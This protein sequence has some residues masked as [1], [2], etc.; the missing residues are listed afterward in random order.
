MSADS[1]SA[2]DRDAWRAALSGM[3]LLVVGMGVGRFA[4]TP[5]LP[6]LREA[7]DWP[8][9]Q[10]GDVASANY[11][12]YVIGALAAAGIA[13]R[14]RQYRWLAVAALASALTTAAG[15]VLDS[16]FGW[17]LLRAA[18]GV[19]SAFVLVLG[20]AIVSR[21]LLAAGRPALAAVYFGG[22]G[23]GIVFSV[24][25]IE[26]GE[27]A[28]LSVFGQWASLGGI[29]VLFAIAALV[30]LGA[31]QAGD[32]RAQDGPAPAP[33]DDSAPTLEAP[34]A[35]TR[36]ALV[37]LIIAYGLFG[38]G[39]VVTATFIVQMA[40]DLPGARLAEPLSWLAVGLCAIPSTA[41]WQWLAGRTGTWR[42]LRIAFLTEAVGV[43]LAGYGGGVLALAGGGAL[44]GGT[45]VGITALGLAAA[46]RI[47]PLRADQV[48][49]WMTAAFGIGQW[50]GPAAAGRLAEASG[51]FALPSLLAA[52]LLGLGFLLLHVRGRR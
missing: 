24:A 47:A 39:Y 36:A 35:A 18:S 7:L 33:V 10:A 13:N 21:R 16:N 26:L 15:A 34:R 43:L 19:A 42:A 8:L 48:M 5:L 4:Y 37:R 6:G 23:V 2:S 9:S 38:F 22:V 20:T 27:A 28:A 1:R 45:F 32:S 25:L 50:I 3:L 12:G 49:G 52:G 29:C 17:L 51:S 41:F 40:R 44:L 46:R 11:L 14:Q 30:L 31:R